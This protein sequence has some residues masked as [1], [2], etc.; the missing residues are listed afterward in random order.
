M[1]TIDAEGKP[2]PGTPWSTLRGRKPIASFE[3]VQKIAEDLQSQS[4]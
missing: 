4:S 3:E 1:M 2:T